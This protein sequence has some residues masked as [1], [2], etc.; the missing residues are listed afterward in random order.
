MTIKTIAREWE[1]IVYL[2]CKNNEEFLFLRRNLK[3]KS[4]VEPCKVLPKKGS[5]KVEVYVQAYY[6]DEG[7]RLTI[8]RVDNTLDTIISI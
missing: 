7:F 4:P 3:V 5:E 8:S 6:S 1:G 2:K